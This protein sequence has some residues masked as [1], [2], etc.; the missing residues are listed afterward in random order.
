VDT[1]VLKRY[2]TTF[3]GCRNKKFEKI[4]KEEKVDQKIIAGKITIFSQ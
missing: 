2:K 1:P 4:E 3:I